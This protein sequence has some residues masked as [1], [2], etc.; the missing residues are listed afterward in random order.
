MEKTYSEVWSQEATSAVS[1]MWP[2]DFPWIFHLPLLVVAGLEHFICVHSVGKN[3]HPSPDEISPSFFRGVRLNHQPDE[4]LK[5]KP[6][7]DADSSGSRMVVR[8]GAV[9]RL[10]KYGYFTMVKW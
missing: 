5:K 9:F 2:E 10:L 3:H 8:L 1:P 4:G 6:Q 7:K